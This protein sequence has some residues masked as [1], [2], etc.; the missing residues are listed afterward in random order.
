MSDL[1]NL[2]IS[3]S[4]Y[5][6]VNLT[7]STEPFASQSE[8]RIYLHDGVG[9][10]LGI[11]LDYT[12]RVSIDNGLTI[13]GSVIVE[14]NKEITG[15]LSV[16]GNITSGDTIS[17]PSASFDT[18]NA[19]LIHTTIESSSII[20]STG[21]NI[22]GDDASDTQTLNGT[23][24]VPNLHYLSGNPKD[25]NLRIDEKLF[26]SSFDSF[27]ASLHTEQLQ[28]DT[29]LNNLSSSVSG[30]QYIQDGRITALENFSTSL[31]DSFVSEVEFASY[32]QS[33]ANEQSVQD[34]RLNSLEAFTSSL[35]ADFVTDAELSSA[36]ETVT[37]SLESQIA[38]KL[39]TG[40]YLTDS[41][42]FDTRIDSKIGSA[43]NNT[44]TGN[45]VFSGS[46]N[47]EVVELSVVSSTATMD[48]SQ[49]NF[50]KLTLPD[51]VETT[52]SATNIQSGQTITL[53]LNQSATSAGTVVYSSEIKF[54]QGITPTMTETLSAID[55]ISFVTFDTGSLFGVNGANFS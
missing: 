24:N 35:V 29:N 44:F 52:I 38:T 40:S 10:N 20:Y 32:T 11:S 23:V 27:S 12:K 13:T 53:Q 5:G 26:T 39:D 41:A 42:S 21:S 43:D 33:I 50:F 19:R 17:A 6:V 8:G 47:G 16:S 45:N 49:G 54:V 22:L 37:S 7:D 18:I 36:L 34:G 2:Y 1:S 15:S 9:E 3:A 30:G 14:G 51:G 46:V 28:Q 31:D 4:Y 25:T 48:C 55:I